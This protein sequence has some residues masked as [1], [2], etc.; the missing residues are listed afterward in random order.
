[1]RA[2]GAGYEVKAAARRA[3][4]RD[5]ILDPGLVRL[6]AVFDQSNDAVGFVDVRALWGADVDDGTLRVA[7]GKE[8]SSL[9]YLG[10]QGHQAE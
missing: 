8:L 9:S 2:A 5:D 1:M 7:L 10:I 6:D 3:H 4:V